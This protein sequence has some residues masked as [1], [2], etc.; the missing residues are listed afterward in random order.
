MNVDVETMGL[1][2]LFSQSP[3]PPQY[4]LSPRPP[5]ATGTGMDKPGVPHPKMQQTEH[6]GT[7]IFQVGVDPFLPVD[8]TM[9]P[10]QEGTSSCQADVG[11][12]PKKPTTVQ[13]AA[14]QEFAR[15]PKNRQQQGVI[16]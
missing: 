15:L 12:N 5:L 3:P 7:F 13:V 14:H 2:I 4:D 16:A 6:E 11:V 8:C 1:E 9:I 10:E